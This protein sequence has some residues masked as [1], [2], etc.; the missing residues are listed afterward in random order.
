MPKPCLAYCVVLVMLL[1]AFVAAWFVTKSGRRC[2]QC[3]V[4]LVPFKPV[5]SDDQATVL[6]LG[7]VD[8]HS[9]ARCPS[10]LREYHRYVGF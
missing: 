1:F 2:P 9:F 5:L 6:L 8:I 4:R 3:G 10:C 7:H